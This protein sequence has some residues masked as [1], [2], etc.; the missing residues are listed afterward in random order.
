MVDSV[1]I[2]GASV[3]GVGAANELRR[4]GFS[5][6]ITLVDG[7]AHLP[8]DRPPL[9][10]GML[11]GQQA[12][13]ELQFHDRDHYARTSIDLQLGA[14]ARM[15]DLDTRTIVLESGQRLTAD[16]IIIA[17]GARARPFPAD[18][19]TGTVHL[20]RDLDDAIRL[21]SLLL[22]GKRLVIIGGGFIGAEVA[23]TAIGLGLKVVVIEAARLPFERILGSQIAARFVGLHVKAGVELLC[24][25]SVE[26]IESSGC[27]QRVFIAG[28]LRID[29]DVVVAGLGSLPN[30]EWLASSRLEISN[31][32]LCDEQGRTGSAGIF[33]AGD[34]AAWRDASN[35]HHLRHEHWTAARE[36]ARIIAQ[37]ISGGVITPWRDF[38]PYFWSDL[39]GVRL[40]MLG[41]AVDADDIRIVHEDEEKRA[42]VAEYRRAGELTGVVGGNAGARTMRY[43][44]KL[45]RKPA[46]ATLDA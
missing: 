29:A 40:Q 32:I 12:I 4:C 16:R 25:V 30:V 26:R 2:V 46:S 36:Q 42:F 34:V 39:H 15:L 11:Y 23:S 8:Y 13:P 43:A 41:S 19:C 35:G 3:A 38:V 45:A 21:R 14:A 33:A 27:E 10:K 24:G 37:S 18:R 31:G 1:L 44:S 22:P 28:N 5:G 17:T 20:L 9:S 6:G 7:Q